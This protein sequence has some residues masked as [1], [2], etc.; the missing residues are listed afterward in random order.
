MIHLDALDAVSA[1]LAGDVGV[2]TWLGVDDADDARARIKATAPAED[3]AWPLIL[4]EEVGGAPTGRSFGEAPANATTEVLATAVVDD[5]QRYDDNGAAIMPPGGTIGASGLTA[6]IRTALDA[7]GGRT[8][9][10]DVG[11][12]E[13]LPDEFHRGPVEV[14]YVEV[15]FGAEHLE[16][17]SDA[18]LR[19]T[20]ATVKTRAVTGA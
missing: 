16:F 3:D 10:E 13:A 17:R 8:I 14:Q 2:Q 11:L 15:A 19:S 1:I 20:R 6:A 5:V 12:R 18:I 7:A 9:H 4:L